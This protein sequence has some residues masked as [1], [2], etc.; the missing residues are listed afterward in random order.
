[1]DDPLQDTPEYIVAVGSQGRPRP[2]IAFT[3]SDFEAGSAGYAASEVAEQFAAH[4]E[5]A[6]SVLAV[7]VC[8]ETGCTVQYQGGSEPRAAQVTANLLSLPIIRGSTPNDELG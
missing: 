4:A 2:Q 7:E 5:A 6:R 1:M 3:D 8:D